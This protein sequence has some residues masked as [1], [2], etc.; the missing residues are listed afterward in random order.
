MKTAAWPSPVMTEVRSLPHITSTRSLGDDGA[1][2][3]LRAARRPRALVGQETVLAHETQDTAPAGADSGKAQSRPQLAIALAMEGAVLLELPDRLGQTLVGHRAERPRPCVHNCRHW[4]AMAVDG[5]PR[6][7]PNP[8]D[9]QETVG[10]LGGGRDLPAHR[11]RGP[12]ATR[13]VGWASTSGGPKGGEPPS[14]RSLPPKARS[15]SSARRPWPA[16][17]RSR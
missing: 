5:R 13:R 4:T 3:G 11:L 7:A 8:G 16:G 10:L 17:G 2:V 14:A 9:P 1:V 15:S 12:H 6:H